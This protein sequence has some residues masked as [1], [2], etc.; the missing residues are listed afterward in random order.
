MGLG[1]GGIGNEGNHWGGSG[2]RGRDGGAVTR[3]STVV[4][5]EGIGESE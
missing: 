4:S 2:D 3:A 1:R 5:T